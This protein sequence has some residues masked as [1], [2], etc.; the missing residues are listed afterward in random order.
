MAIL[1]NKYEI[2]IWEDLLDTS[3]QKYGYSKLETR[4]NDWSSS[5]YSHYYTYNG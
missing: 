1:K 5:N 2:S 4:P 3:D